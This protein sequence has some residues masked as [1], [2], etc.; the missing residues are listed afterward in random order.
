MDKMEKIRQRIAE[1]KKLYKWT[2]NSLAR[3]AAT[4]KRL[5][6]QLSHGGTITLETLLLILEACPGL[7]S[8]WLL[9]GRGDMML[10]PSESTENGAAPAGDSTA[11][12][13]SLL[14]EK[15][16]QIDRLLALLSR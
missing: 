14:E 4:Q 6:R 1:V 5:N 12:F 10:P 15:D 9:F 2:E 7:S 16:R 3:D 13:L 11:R 8:D